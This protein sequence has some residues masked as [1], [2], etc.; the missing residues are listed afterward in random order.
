MKGDGRFYFACALLLLA[1]PGCTHGISAAV[2]LVDSYAMAVPTDDPSPGE[3][4]FRQANFGLQGPGVT[5]IT[6]D[7]GGSIPSFESRFFGEGTDNTPWV[8]GCYCN[9]AR[10]V[11]LGKG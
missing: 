3:R 5:A 9:S 11:V 7:E 4:G 1:L 10:T 8:G 6:A 2:P